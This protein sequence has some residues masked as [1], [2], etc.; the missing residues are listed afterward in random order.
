MGHLCIFE[1]FPKV[2]IKATV[3][4]YVVFD[5]ELKTIPSRLKSDN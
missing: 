2:A 3:D 1:K 5:R 4:V